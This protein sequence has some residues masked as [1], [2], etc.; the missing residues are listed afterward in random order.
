MVTEAK[1]GVEEVVVAEE[2]AEG[3]M[4]ARMCDFDEMLLPY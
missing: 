2:D 4:M 1:V 3:E